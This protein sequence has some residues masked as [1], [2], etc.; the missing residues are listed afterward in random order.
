MG[1]IEN[2]ITEIT[3]VK[4]AL[5][6]KLNLLKTQIGTLPSLT[7][8]N[9]NSL[10]EAI[11]ELKSTTL[12]SDP[13]Y[14]RTSLQGAA[15]STTGVYKIILG[16]AF[17][18]WL[19]IRLTG[20]YSSQNSNGYIEVTGGVGANTGSSI[21][22]N[23]LV[24][25]TAIGQTVVVY[26]IDPV[27]KV[28]ASGNK[29]IEIHKK[30]ANSN[31]L[32]LDIEFLSN[33]SV[34][35]TYNPYVDTVSTTGVQTLTNKATVFGLKGSNTRM[36]TVNNMGEL[37]S[38]AI[39]T[40]TTYS[41]GTGISQNGT[42]FGQ[43][44][45]TSGTGTFIA[46]INQTTNGFQINYGT[47]PNT[48]TTY[49]QMTNTVLGLGKLFS[50]TVQ[51]VA[52]NAVSS[53]ASRTYGVQVNSSGQLVVNVPWVNTS[54]S[55]MTSTQWGLGRLYTDDIQTGHAAEIS[56]VDK[57]TYGV[58]FNE[59]GQLV[60]NVPWEENQGQTYSAGTVAMLQSPNY[61]P[62]TYVWSPYVLRSYMYS[63]FIHKGEDN[64]ADPYSFKLRMNG[65]YLTGTSQ[66]TAIVANDESTEDIWDGRFDFSFE[67][68]MLSYNS[69]TNSGGDSS[70][71][72]TPN[73]MCFKNYSSIAYINTEVSSGSHRVALP[74]CGEIERFMVV[75][76][77]VGYAKYYAGIN[78]MVNLPF[79]TF[80]SYN[81]AS[82]NS[83]Y[84]INVYD[85]VVQNYTTNSSLTLTTSGHGTVN[86]A[87]ITIIANESTAISLR[88]DT[89]VRK[90]NSSGTILVA[91]TTITIP[92]R[93]TLIL[94]RV[95]NIYYSQLIQ[96]VAW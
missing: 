65:G 52:A 42:V 64:T 2:L 46:S 15:I 34:P 38:Q 41:A 17:N 36:V 39:P 19:K 68:R 28:D 24:C 62:I 54:Y 95:T 11:N 5:I 61:T 91:N 40:D 30:S 45:T 75:G 77:D 51:S 3:Q 7:T 29:Y 96:R 88:I 43:T 59:S 66:G 32:F 85:A 23:E 47:P 86:G 16:T 79:G 14:R 76:Y 33:S 83:Y 31:G 80:A 13:R 82:A 9:K 56:N 10:V 4:D 27:V 94:K 92:A 78:G 69:K 25:I 44:I 84:D 22:N 90:T 50:S 67:E 26:Y 6:L 93:H 12:A 53:T 8:T 1:F 18:G 74:S 87:T 37:E 58:Q 73:S 49:T 35:T 63:N 57:R 70:F 20:S 71:Y 89:Q 55:S 81:T 60:V 72:V 21:W 48:N